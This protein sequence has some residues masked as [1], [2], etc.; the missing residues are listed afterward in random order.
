MKILITYYSLSG[1]TE[2]IAT[3]MKNALENY[4]V[5]LIKIENLDSS[6][7]KDYD[8]VLLGSGVYAGSVH[9]SVKK[10]IKNIEVFPPKFALFDTHSSED[11]A[12][13]KDAF[14]KIKKTILGNNCEIVGEFDCL[15]ENKGIS[16]QK[17]LEQIKNL[18]E[19]KQKEAKK[20]L[21]RIKGHPNEEDLKKAME[22]V[23]SLI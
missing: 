21:K 9:K 23:R 12:H 16:E 19:D 8:L 4:E 10:L 2:K 18:P 11:A 6:L 22:F 15:G 20:Q 7:I 1:N 3:H 17:Q 14:K 13:H 5:E